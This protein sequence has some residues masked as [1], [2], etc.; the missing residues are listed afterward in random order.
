LPF[1]PVFGGG[2]SLFQPVYVG[3]LAHLVEILSRKPDS[4]V[5][6]KLAGEVIEAGGPQT[7]THRELMQMVLD[8]TKRNKPIISLPFAVGMLQGYIMEKLPLNLF[9]VTRA[10]IQQLKTDNIVNV[11]M[12]TKHISL[13]EVMSTYSDEP[14]TSIQN[15]LPSYLR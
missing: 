9:T 1:L 3:D 13:E 14:L 15:I 5:G 6:Q 12:P 8:V 2:T 7:F 11:E 4:D 10:Q